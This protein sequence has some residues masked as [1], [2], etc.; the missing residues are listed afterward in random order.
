MTRFRKNEN[1]RRRGMRAENESQQLMT[2]M[3]SVRQNAGKQD[4][5]PELSWGLLVHYKKE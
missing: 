5:S 4:N 3:P 2:A 1:S